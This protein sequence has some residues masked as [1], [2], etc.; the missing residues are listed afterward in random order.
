MVHVS[1][2][3][4]RSRSRLLRK[5]PRGQS[6]RVFPVRGLAQATRMRSQQAIVSV[7]KGPRLASL[8]SRNVAARLLLESHDNERL[9]R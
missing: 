2:G 5:H 1:L 9:Y 4:V 7:V 8:N 3:P 6:E